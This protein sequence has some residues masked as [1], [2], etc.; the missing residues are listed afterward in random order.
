MEKAIEYLF[1]GSQ[2]DEWLADMWMNVLDGFYEQAMT[3]QFVFLMYEDQCKEILRSMSKEDMVH[4]SQMSYI[5][6]HG[7]KMFKD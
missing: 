2:A 1:T 6:Q 4:L 5:A 3:S 7:R